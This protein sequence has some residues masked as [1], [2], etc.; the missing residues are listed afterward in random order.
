MS[1][2]ILGVKTNQGVLDLVTLGSLL[3]ERLREVQ[4][5]FDVCPIL[6]GGFFVIEVEGDWKHDHARVD[7]NVRNLFDELGIQHYDIYTIPTNTTESDYYSAKH[8]VMMLSEGLE[9]TEVTQL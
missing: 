9:Y 2:T 6:E 5:Y 4:L 3:N 7:L 1:D 8:H